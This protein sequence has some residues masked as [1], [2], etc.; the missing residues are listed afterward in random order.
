M[1]HVEY[2]HDDKMTPTFQTMN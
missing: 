2:V 1:K